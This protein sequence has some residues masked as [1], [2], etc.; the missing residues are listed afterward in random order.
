L[1]CSYKQEKAQYEAQMN[2]LKERMAELGRE[3]E[4]V[5]VD[6]VKYVDQINEMKKEMQQLRKEKETA[7]RKSSRQVSGCYHQA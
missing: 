1:C 7:E 6:R 3:Y 5:D 4:K 2:N